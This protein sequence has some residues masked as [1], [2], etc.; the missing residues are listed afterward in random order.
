M[1]LLSGIKTNKAITTLLE[2]DNPN[3]PAVV[4]A[5]HKIKEIGHNAVPRLIDALLDSPGNK[6]IERLLVTLL[7]KKSLRE[8]VDALTD[9]NRNLVTSIARIMASS[10]NY[11]P[12]QLLPYLDDPEIPKNILLQILIAKKSRLNFRKVIGLL[13]KADKNKRTM[14]FHLIHAIATPEIIPFLMQYV[15][16]PELSTRLQTIR[17]LSQFNNDTVRHVLIKALS[18]PNKMVRQTALDGISSHNIVVPVTTIC[19]LLRD[20]DMTVQSKAIEALIRLK[21]PSTVMHLIEILNDDSEYVRRA[22]VEILNETAD[23]RAIKNLL[24]AMRDSDWWVRV[25]AADALGTIGGPRVVEAVLSLLQDK[26]EFLRRTAVEIL[27]S[28]KDERAYFYLVQ[29]LADEDW[30][31]RERAVDA[32]GKLGDK[33]AI[34]ELFTTMERF[35]ESTHIIVQSL[36]KIGD[37]DIVQQLRRTGPGIDRRRR[38]IAMFAEC[39]PRCQPYHADKPGITQGNT[40]T[41]RG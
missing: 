23:P 28:V 40:W 3:D 21:D 36:V 29:A 5:V 1:S 10:N 32:L 38:R 18:D 31:V 24:N 35:P 13:E 22:A 6:I 16:D 4:S 12:N 20:P 26:D 2:S 19:P 17:T 30:W 15:D 14:A 33:R 39:D 9:T 7:D 34:P 41:Q 25:R 27:N 37:D 11:D 8:Y